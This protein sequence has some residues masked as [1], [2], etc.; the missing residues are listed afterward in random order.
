MRLPRLPFAL[1][2]CVVAFA[3]CSWVRQASMPEHEGGSC[4]VRV[5]QFLEWARPITLAHVRG[6]YVAAPEEVNASFAE[7]PPAVM[8]LT[9]RVAAAIFWTTD[10]SRV[11]QHADN[12]DF[13][14]ALMGAL[15]TDRGLDELLRI[16]RFGPP[17]Y[18]DR[19][20][21]IFADTGRAGVEY[22]PT[23]KEMLDDP[24]TNEAARVIVTTALMRCGHVRKLDVAFED[25]L[26]ELER[27]GNVD[28]NAVAVR[29]GLFGRAEA[30]ILADCRLFCEVMVRTTTDP[31]DAVR[32]RM[33]TAFRSR[34][35]MCPP[36]ALQPFAELKKDEARVVE[37]LRKKG[38]L[39]D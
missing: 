25:A 9:V 30:K 32:C 31:K 36:F 34:G 8:D 35:E 24:T 3:G 4:E 11:H 39:D 15:L 5:T 21:L 33:Q 6:G 16:A 10:P 38:L 14:F 27:K 20:L 13:A 28:L 29:K 19:A 18:R 7:L 17:P 12:K 22:V 37:L 1:S 2:F 23:L 26:S